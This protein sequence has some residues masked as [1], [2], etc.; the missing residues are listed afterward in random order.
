MARTRTAQVQPQ[1]ITSVEEVDEALWWSTH[2]HKRDHHWQ[3]WIDA[4][5][6]ER[7]RIAATQG[8]R[9]AQPS[10]SPTETEPGT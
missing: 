9:P 10:P 2:Q 1:H 3:R 5:L 4:L 6:D 8:Q 7:N